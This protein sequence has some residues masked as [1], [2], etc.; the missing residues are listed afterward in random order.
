[1]KFKNLLQLFFYILLLSSCSDIADDNKNANNPVEG[2]WN[3]Y[4][5][6]GTILQKKIYTST[7]YTYFLIIDGEDVSTPNVQRYTI[8]NGDQLVFDSYT[9]TFRIIN[10]T[11]WITNSSENKI[12]KYIRQHQIIN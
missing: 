3:I 9:Q 6:S 7:F 8:F 2:E 12:T 1:M 10:D 11:L 5:D 4:S